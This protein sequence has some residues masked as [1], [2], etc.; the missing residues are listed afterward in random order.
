MLPGRAPAPVAQKNT[1]AQI[2]SIRKELAAKGLHRGN[3]ASSVRA[4]ASL[5][6][7][8]FACTVCDMLT[9]LL[10]PAQPA[11]ARPA[12]TQQTY[13]EYEAAAKAPP[14]QPATNAWG[15]R[16]PAAKCVLECL[17]GLC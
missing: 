15:L 4:W 9:V 8:T 10:L 6:Q 1:K 17:R 14:S 16:T 7:G 3:T 12:P 2:D 11:P 13:C 5:P